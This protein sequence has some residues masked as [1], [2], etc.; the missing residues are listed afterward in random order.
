MNVI[1]VPEVL[2]SPALFFLCNCCLWIFFCL[3]LLKI[4]LFYVFLSCIILL[5]SY[6]CRNYKSITYD[7]NVDACPD[8]GGNADVCLLRI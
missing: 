7:K 3:I 6:P 2:Q 1:L 4:Y 5:F 8:S